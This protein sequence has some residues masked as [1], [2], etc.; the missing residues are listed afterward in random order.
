LVLASIIRDY[1]LFARFIEAHCTSKRTALTVS[2]KK[3]VCHNTQLALWG[4]RK[5][6]I[7]LTRGKEQHDNRFSPLG[8]IQNAVNDLFPFPV[9][10]LFYN[11]KNLT[12][13]VINK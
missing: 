8:K 13:P 2:E 12:L 6:K 9:M 11:H 7:D 5:I 4:I 3:N 1:R 10:D